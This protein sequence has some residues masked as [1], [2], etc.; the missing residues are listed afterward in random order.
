MKKIILGILLIALSG[1]QS[2]ASYD[3]PLF[4]ETD[5]KIITTSDI[6][7]F[8]PSLFE[9]GPLFTQVLENGD[10]KILHHSVDI[11]ANFVDNI[12]QE[13]ADVLIITGDLT[14]NGEATSHHSLVRYLHQIEANGTKVFV[15]PGNHDID[16]PRA[17]AYHQ[18]DI[19]KV[20]N[21]SQKDFTKIYKDFGYSGKET[22]LDPN[23]LS[24]LIK[25]SPTQSLFML[26]S[27]NNTQAGN[28]STLISGSLPQATRD[29]MA[30]MLQD[31]NETHQTIVAMHHNLYKHSEVINQGFTLDNASTVQQFFTQHKVALVFSGHIHIQH[32]VDNDIPEI[33]SGSLSIA[34]NQYGRLKLDGV[35]FDYKTQAISFEHPHFPE[36]SKTYFLQ[37]AHNK[38]LK[39]MESA[40]INNTDKNTIAAILAEVN[41]I[42]FSGNTVNDPDSYR[43]KPI[44]TFMNEHHILDDYFESILNKTKN[45]TSLS[46]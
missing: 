29:W 23:S 28:S 43:K 32:I 15:I 13:Q 17:R 44:Y 21:I 11:M 41:Y 31:T 26:D 25:L 45:S 7:F 14:L 38:F 19:S 18:H 4:G 36:V 30:L 39:R 10:G 2:T 3:A 6:H 34:P 35:G 20:K 46:R 27:N 8:D 24:Y 1:C 42:Y 37:V 9:E 22:I 5:L 33:A 12:K 40:T 16:N